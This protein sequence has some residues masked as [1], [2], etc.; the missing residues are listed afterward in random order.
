MQEVLR[1]YWGYAFSEE[2]IR[3]PIQECMQNL[4][5]AMAA[6]TDPTSG[7]V[8]MQRLVDAVGVAVVSSNSWCESSRPGGTLTLQKQCFKALEQA[9]DCFNVKGDGAPTEAA[10]SALCVSELCQKALNSLPELANLPEYRTWKQTVAGWA[11]K[12]KPL[13]SEEV[14]NQKRKKLVEVLRQEKCEDPGFLSTSLSEACRTCRGILLQDE[15]FADG[16][17]AFATV[18]HLLTA[19]AGAEP[20][21]MLKFA[22]PCESL[23]AHLPEKNDE[24]AMSALANIFIN[25][26]NLRV[27]STEFEK[28]G[29]DTAAKIVHD[30]YKLV[31]QKIIAAN[32]RAE[33]C[34]SDFASESKSDAIF[35]GRAAS[36]RDV[37]MRG[38]NNLKALHESVASGI[39]ECKQVLLK[40]AETTLQE[41][42]L[43][44]EKFAYGCSDGKKWKNV[45]LSGEAEQAEG[46]EGASNV[47]EA[48]KRW[49]QEVF[50]KDVEPQIA[51]L[52]KP[53]K[54]AYQAML[55]VLERYSVS[56]EEWPK[57]V[58]HARLI[59]ASSMATSG[60]A[61]LVRAIMDQNYV[62]ET[63]SQLK[64]LANNKFAVELDYK[65]LLHPKI[66]AKAT[67]L[68]R[69]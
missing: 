26:A 36:L 50:T 3:G 9:V 58:A 16:T 37:A 46:E 23:A 52:F 32:L 44:L 67:E 40:N 12:L 33:Q 55:A 41:N 53:A 10:V 18:E 22:R 68:S 4:V 2:S 65:R 35:Q 64:R 13:V 43:Q 63:S 27:A 30:G 38:I 39:G 24:T 5:A 51:N 6:Q 15:D 31:E 47:I 1:V 69:Q 17:A 20:A 25:A 11:E 54:A 62:Q 49:V 42:L 66:V 61:L 7:P 34:L 57:N 28:L 48:A 45:F 29:K 19:A 60:E 21:D 56:Q 8:E 14:V 59:L